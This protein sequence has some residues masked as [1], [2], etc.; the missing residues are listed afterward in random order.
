MIKEKTI[1]V[2]YRLGFTLEELDA[3]MGY[4]FDYEGMNL[5][6]TAEDDDANSITFIMPGIFNVTD[7]NRVAVLEAMAK[8]SLKVK[9]VQPVIML[10]GVW[11]QYQ[12]YIEEDQEP[13][14]RLIEHMIHVLTVSTM[15]FHNILNEE[16]NDE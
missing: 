16:S 4:R 8:L 5:L 1:E 2:L 15:Q 14:E 9:Y 12:H 6:Y 3:D 7:E 13:T 11:L 10:D